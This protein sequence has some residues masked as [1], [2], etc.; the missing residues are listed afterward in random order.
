MANKEAKLT[1]MQLISRWA[2]FFVFYF[3]CILLIASFGL[4]AEF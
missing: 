4:V 2:W 3:F 1:E